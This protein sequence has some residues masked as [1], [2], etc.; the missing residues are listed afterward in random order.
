V[1]PEGL[2]RFKN[3][4]VLHNLVCADCNSYFGNTLDRVLARE[5]VEGLE[6]YRSGVKPSNEI[7]RFR[8]DAVTLRAHDAGEFTGAE[9]RIIPG[10]AEGE[11]AAEILGSAAVRQTAGDQFEYFSEAQILD[12][13]WKSERVDARRGIRLFG[14]DEAMSRMRLALESQG[15][16]LNYRPLRPPESQIPAVLQEYTISL[17]HRR[18][19]AKIAFNY[20]AFRCGS[21]LVLST[22]FDPIRAFVRFGTEPPLPPVQVSDNLPFRTA[23]PPEERPIV[24]F[25]SITGDTGHRNLLGSMTLFGYH[26]Y[27]IVLAESF[28]GPWPEL[29]IAHLYNV[30]QLTV[31]E[32]PAQ[33]PRWR[34]ENTD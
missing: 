26:G 12:G 1:V 20:L 3:A 29:P 25:V 23:R 21:E 2:G 7:S 30:K 11:F 34:H 28:G 19:V 24:H 9:L 31:V 14:P 4:L 32:L 22:A 6:R 10:S 15:F 17:M 33:L 5:S 27:T 8:G 16:T 18:A 13:S